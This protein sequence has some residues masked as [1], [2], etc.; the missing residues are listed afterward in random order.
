[1]AIDFETQKLL[2]FIRIQWIE[3]PESLRPEKV[4]VCSFKPIAEHVDHNYNIN[5]S[6]ERAWF[7][8]HRGLEQ[9]NVNEF[10]RFAAA[11]LDMPWHSEGIHGPSPVSPL[12]WAS[13]F[14]FG[15][16]SFAKYQNSSSHYLQLIW[17]RLHGRGYVVQ[18][19]SEKF[20]ITQELWKS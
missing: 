7:L 19:E 18:L 12:I 15:L 8:N 3:L 11:H 6:I 13:T 4:W 1:M 14:E 16:V 17:G 10:S 2:E 20:A 9:R 5:T